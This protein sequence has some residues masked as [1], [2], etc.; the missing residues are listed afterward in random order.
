MDEQ[1]VRQ[2]KEIEK[3]EQQF[4]CVR[5]VQMKGVDLRLFQFDYD[6]TWA[7]SFLNAD[8]TIY[9]RFGTRASVRNNS[10]S[11]I[12]LASFRKALERALELHK[13]YPGNKDRLAGKRG[14]EPEYA[15]AEKIPGLAKA[16]C[17][18]CHN[19]RDYPLRLKWQEKKLTAADL[20][21]YPLP[22]NIGLRMDV[23]DG[24]KVKA[25]LKDS[26][27]AR[28]G[29]GLVALNGQPLISQA[30][31]QWVLHNAPAEAK[32]AATLTRGQDTLQKTIALGGGWK[33]SDL[34]WRESSWY[35]LRQGLKVEPLPAA[36][37]K[38][39][40]IPE[41]QMALAV[42]GMFGKGPAPLQKAGLRVGDV[43]VAVG[44]KT[45]LLTE[46]R[47]LAYVRLNHGPDDKVKLVVLR[48]KERHELTVPMW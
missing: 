16:E 25:V 44:D 5:L 31:I 38:K 27:A 40:D 17:I 10:M 13:G 4:V 37:R 33:E 19:V 1:V 3:L 47:F 29:D 36:E 34:A 23:D 20:Y 9:G 11:H 8:G 6:Q 14:P 21:V 12:S 7:V 43:I 35:G 24:L 39:Q 32:L 2:D 28:A 45:D 42:R 26:P 46:G 48:N 30:D 18:H 22:E 41:G 15:A